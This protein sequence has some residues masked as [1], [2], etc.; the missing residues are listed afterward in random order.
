MERIV[1]FHALVDSCLS[2]PHGHPFVILSR[3]DSVISTRE[4]GRNLSTLFHRLCKPDPHL[5]PWGEAGG[6]RCMETLVFYYGAVKDFSVA[7]AP[8]K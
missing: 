2:S 4:A 7:D 3:A 5:P 8:S 1:T 6:G